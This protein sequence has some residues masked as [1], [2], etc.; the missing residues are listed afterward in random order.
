MTGR[1]LRANGFSVAISQ[2]D[3][4]ATVKSLSV[5]K[6]DVILNLAYGWVNRRKRIALQQADVAEVLERCEV[7]MVGASSKAQRLAQ[8]KVLAG[9]IAQAEGI[10]TPRTIDL[11]ARPAVLPALCVL[12]PRFGAC[13]R[14]VRIVDPA[15]IRKFD[16]STELLQEYIP[17]NEITVGALW[18]KGRLR[19]L[20]PIEVRFHSSPSVKDW[21]RY[22]WTYRVRNTLTRRL[23]QIV[24]CLFSRFELHD[25]ARFDF[26]SSGRGWI[27]LDVNALP[28]LHPTDSMLPMAA[29]A[30]GMDY[31]ALIFALLESALLRARG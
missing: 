3:P 22:R 7:P 21:S 8:D 18:W 6:P 9:S 10:C 24:R 15:G 5:F 23:A 1:L 13:G 29:R 12:K 26:R 14:D 16:S 19:I 27:L 2:F 11:S 30:V 31:A 25:Y 28:N 17:G 4:V 20:P